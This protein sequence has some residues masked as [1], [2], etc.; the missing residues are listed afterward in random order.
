MSQSQVVGGRQREALTS[1]L[2]ARRVGEP[3]VCE[4]TCAHAALETSSTVRER[5]AFEWS[6][7]AA[8]VDLLKQAPRRTDASS[9]LSLRPSRLTAR[10]LHSV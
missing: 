5:M 2:D 4:Q 10:L 1:S 3:R 9:S 8:P 6:G 7:Q